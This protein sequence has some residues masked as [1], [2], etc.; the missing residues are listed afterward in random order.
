LLRP[1]SPAAQKRIAQSNEVRLARLKAL[2]T[3][4]DAMQAVLAE[5]AA[6]LPSL[7]QGGGYVKLLEGLIL[8]G[9]IQV[10]EA[11]VSLKGVSGQGAVVQKAM[12]AAVPKFKEW[13][14]KNM[15][16]AFADA[17]EVHSIA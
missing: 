7:T 1:A 3:R 4:D 13:G 11:K 5:A 6:K 17:I 16:D 12:A 15:G 8:E 2:K 10:Q 9:L 14:K